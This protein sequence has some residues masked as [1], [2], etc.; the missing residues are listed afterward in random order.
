MTKERYY[1]NRA[2]RIRK[3]MEQIEAKHPEADFTDTVFRDDFRKYIELMREV[4][5][6]RVNADEC[7]SKDPNRICEGCECWKKGQ[8]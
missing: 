8:K 2:A 3:R 6:A 5:Y 4:V 7:H 1:R